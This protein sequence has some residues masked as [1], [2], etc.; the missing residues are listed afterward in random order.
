VKRGGE[1]AWGE[2]DG[3]VDAEKL[4]AKWAPKWAARL[5]STVDGKPVRRAALS[6]RYLGLTL[7]DTSYRGVGV[8]AGQEGILRTE[9]D[10]AVETTKLP[11]RTLF[12]RATALSE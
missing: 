8:L 3:E 1:E 12:L 9:V 11:V 6:S 4:S 7:L 10:V 5:D 2:V